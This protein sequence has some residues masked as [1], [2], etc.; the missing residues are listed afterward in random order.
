MG[1]VLSAAVSLRGRLVILVCLATLPAILFAFL[2]ADNERAAALQRMEGDSRHIV[3]LI[4][5]EHFYQVAG[6]KQLLHW[7]ANHLVT[8]ANGPSLLK[9]PGLLPALL[10]GYPQLA[11]IAI[12]T[13]DGDVTASAHPLPGPIN[14]HDYDAI[15]RALRSHEIEA[16]VYAM[17]PIVRR[18]ILHLAYAVRSA[19]GAALYVV[20][21][22]IDLEWLGRLTEQVE[23]PTEHILIIVDRDGRVLAGS[24][25]PASP[26][27]PVGE[28]IPEL[29]ESARGG[30]T[31][32]TAEIDGRPQPFAVAPMEGVP[33]VLV[34]SGL[35]YEPIYAKA[36]S[37]FF[38]AI[39]WL[40]LLTLLTVASV[41]LF[42]EVALIRYL[43]GL[44]QAMH[45]FGGGDFS[46]RAPVSLGRGELQDMAQT[47]NG[48][49]AALA[50]R[51]NELAE[52]H[53]RLDLLARH[54]Q[55][56]RESEAQRIARDLH[57]EAGQ[58][59]TS[60]KIDLAG[61]QRKCGLCAR[62]G[63]ANAAV[64]ADAEAMK[65]KIDHMIAFIRRLASALRPPVLDKM[66]LPAAMQLL[67]ADVE[68]NSDLAVEL[69]ITDIERPLDWLVSTTLY[70]IAQEALTNIVRHAE[71]SLAHIDLRGSRESVTLVVKDNGA[72]LPAGGEGRDGLGVIGMRE[73]AN[74]VGGS[75]SIEG[76]GGGGTV[77]TVVIPNED[78]GHGEHPPG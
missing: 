78:G 3:G 77:I 56:A 17:G 60:L 63:A 74:L 30:E 64:E 54:L 47:F 41:I 58:V 32:I 45:R 25:G 62:S 24:T 71:A 23:L 34:A 51:H 33:G 7:L 73:R 48:M 22:A 14:M 36:N 19:E 75:F 37:I 38:R 16:G 13:P 76:A 59:L 40:T 2:I 42:E 21:V 26:A 4:S 6:A 27:I 35:P 67:A 29:A 55:V 1:N 53:G 15:R 43:R 12:L 28:R 66:G 69:E 57:D 65:G 68:K 49:A 72:G 8:A 44:A 20:F 50:A 61:L 39:G 11:N 52:A 46:A 70:R 5:R 10:A 9:D 18:P 31:M